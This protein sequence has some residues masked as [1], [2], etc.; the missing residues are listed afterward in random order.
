MNAALEG[1]VYPAVPFEVDAARVRRFAD[2]V[3]GAPHRVPPT[4]VT[5]AEVAAGFAAVVADPDLGLDF[6]RVVHAEQSY[7]W[8]RPLAVG[9]RLEA[10]CTIESIRE[11]A[12]AGFLVLRTDLRDGQGTTVATARAT[13]LERSPR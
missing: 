10:V 11:R 4:F 12:G 3:G 7:E 13:L 9:E 5:A 8:R 6:T 1:K 2:V